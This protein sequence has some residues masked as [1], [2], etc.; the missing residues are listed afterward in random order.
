[1][2]VG[3]KANPDYWRGA[4]KIDLLIFSITPDPAVR[5]KRLQAGECR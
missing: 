5:L 4:P 2:R 3:Y 1:V